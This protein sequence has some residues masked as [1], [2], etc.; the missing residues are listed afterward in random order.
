MITMSGVFLLYTAVIVPIQLFL[1]SYDDPCVLFPTLYLDLLV[2]S[3]FLVRVSPLRRARVRA[4]SQPPE[5]AC[6]ARVRA[7]IGR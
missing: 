6:L 4:L 1:W 5:P 7:C 2:D 3:F